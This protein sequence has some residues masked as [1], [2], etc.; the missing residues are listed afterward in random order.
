MLP[1]HAKG[2]MPNSASCTSPVLVCVGGE[3]ASS[4]FIKLS[5]VSC[6]AAAASNVKGAGEQRQQGSNNPRVVL[7]CAWEAGVCYYLQQQ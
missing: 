2:N 4:C 7:A 5:E 6:T 3:G 1:A